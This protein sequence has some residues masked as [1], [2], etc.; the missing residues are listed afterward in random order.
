MVKIGTFPQFVNMP[1]FAKTTEKRKNKK[2]GKK[3]ACTIV[4]VHVSI[5]RMHKLC[6]CM[7]KVRKA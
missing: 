2:K 3:A 6:V 5:L 7:P 4:V 1:Q